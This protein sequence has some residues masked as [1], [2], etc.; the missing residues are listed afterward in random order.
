MQFANPQFLIVRIDDGDGDPF[1]LLG[2]RMTVKQAIAAARRSYVRS[3]TMF[4]FVNLE[5][6]RAVVLDDNGFI[7]A[8]DWL[9]PSNDSH[10]QRFVRD[11]LSN[12]WSESQGS[13]P[14][15]G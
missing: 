3:P 4:E 6:A 2:G 12:S 15:E 13:E 8:S 5:T 14:E 1:A 11:I 7:V 9:V 10:D